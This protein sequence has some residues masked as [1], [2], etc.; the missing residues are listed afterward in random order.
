MKET[1]ERLN[2]IWLNRDFRDVASLAA[3]GIID[4]PGEWDPPKGVVPRRELMFLSIGEPDT[5]SLPRDLINNAMRQVMNRKDDSALRYGYGI[6]YFPIRKYLSERYSRIRGFEVTEDWFWLANGSS[7]AIDMVVR[8]LIDPGDVIIAE[9]PTYMGTLKNFRAMM[10]DIHTVPVDSE[11]LD[12]DQLAQKVQELRQKGKRVKL[13]YT[14]SSFQNPA[15]VTLS[16][17]RKEKLLELAAEEGFLILDDDAYGELYYENQPSIPLSALSEGSG[18]ITVG[19]FSKIVATGL[20]IGWIHAHPDFFKTFGRMRFDM[21]Q[22]QMA[23]RMMGR[24]LSDGHLEEHV[25][26]VRALYQKKMNIIS[27]AIEKHAGEY[28]SFKQPQGGFYL[29][30]TLADGLTANNVWRTAME[31]GV[32]VSPGFAFFPDR[33][34]KSGEHLRIAFAWTPTDQLEEAV[35]RIA[36]ACRRVQSGDSA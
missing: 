19:T 4:S 35:K 11:G 1:K 8:A 20:R 9:A 28:L 36:C 16:R 14:I 30:I 10:A 15:G 13:V 32:L 33:V 27:A 22:N 29:W 5:D 12:T 31:E 7:S 2:R 17:D 24:F 6:G 25:K 34:D 3:K 18:V 21:G 26:R 23:L